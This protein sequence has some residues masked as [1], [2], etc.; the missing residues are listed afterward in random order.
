MGGRTDGQGHSKAPYNYI[1]AG[2]KHMG[3]LTFMIIKMICIC[4]TTEITYVVF[5]CD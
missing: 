2:S 4:F 5:R 3:F 1:V